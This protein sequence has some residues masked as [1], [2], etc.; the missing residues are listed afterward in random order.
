MLEREGENPWREPA[1]LGAM[2]SLF[3][4]PCLAGFIVHASC[5]VSGGYRAAVVQGLF[6]N[7]TTSQA[8]LVESF[9]R[10][11]AAAQTQ[12]IV[13]A[14]SALGSDTSLNHRASC[15]PLPSPGAAVSLCGAAETPVASM[16]SCLAAKYHIVLVFCA[17]DV[18]G[19]EHFNTQL[20]VDSDGRLLAKYHKMHLYDPSPGIGESTH[21]SYPAVADPSYFDTKFGVRFGM[22]TCFDMAFSTPGAAMAMDP[23]LGIRDFVF[24]TGWVVESPPMLPPNAVQ[25][26][27]SRGVGVNLLAA[28]SAHSF[29]SS[30]SGI[31]SQGQVLAKRV[32]PFDSPDSGHMLIADVPKL[33]RS[34]PNVQQRPPN[35]GYKTFPA[36]PAETQSSHMQAAGN[37]TVAVVKLALGLRSDAVT[38]VDAASPTGFRCHL[39]YSLSHPLREQF[40]LLALD[41]HWLRGVIRSRSC[42]LFRCRTAACSVDPLFVSAVDLKSSTVFERV[43]MYGDFLMGDVVMPIVATSR[44]DVADDLDMQVQGGSLVMP[45]LNET[46]LSAMLYASL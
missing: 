15:E 1:E 28:D 40:A 14:E 26:G 27:W 10:D 7:A 29:G 2:R 25:Q 4:L 18:R 16:M 22:H 17:C 32:T 5:G 9:V 36:H 42:L 13:F 11:A 38:S 23:S 30:G 34:Q 6:H 3:A 45:H 8:S 37:G 39:V 41:G 31:Y 43:A 20:A 21:A 44:G 24:P 33:R 46:L 35:W 12:I 19:K